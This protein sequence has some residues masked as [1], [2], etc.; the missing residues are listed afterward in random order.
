L[1]FLA[2]RRELSAHSPADVAHAMA[3]L[4]LTQI[5]LAAMAVCL[6]F[7]MLSGYDWIAQIYGGKTLPYVKTLT[8]SFI[9]F[10]MGN[11][12]GFNAVTAG[13]VRLRL[14]SRS[15]LK[16]LDSARITAFNVLTF[17]VGLGAA[18][19]TAL[20]LG[21]LQ[22]PPRAPLWLPSPRVAGG[23]LLLSVVAYLLA[24]CFWP[25]RSLWGVSQIRIPSWRVGL[26]QI[27][28][29][30]GE[31]V[32]AASVLWILL[33]VHSAGFGAVLGVFVV[34]VLLGLVSTVPGG[35]GVFEASALFFLGHEIGA[36][37]VLG[38]ILVYRL[39]YTFAPF[40]GALLLFALAEGQH[41][42]RQRQLKRHAKRH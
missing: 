17:W 24:C 25:G 22:W 13:L 35:L 34:S 30:S 26:G 20:L 11:A 29:G 27:A 12:L 7:V 9:A 40:L 16:A 19:G 28:I 36:A 2:I 1:A 33:P 38:S 32:L 18:G 14:Y 41:R 5:S 21:H 31:W 8:T 15:G 3:S 23:V 39:C 6:T 42:S 37:R 4:S 10:A